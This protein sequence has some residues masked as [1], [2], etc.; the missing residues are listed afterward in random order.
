MV[1]EK[2]QVVSVSVLIISDLSQL[3]LR[4]FVCIHDLSFLDRDWEWNEWSG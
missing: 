1:R 4:M 3:S 2:F